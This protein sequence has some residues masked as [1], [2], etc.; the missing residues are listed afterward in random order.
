MKLSIIIPVYNVEK[1][2]IDC[3]DSIY[4]NEADLNQVE[5]LCIDDK[6]NDN[7]I[8]LIKEYVKSNKISNLTILYHQQNKGLSEARNTGI[9]QATGKYICFL[10]SD[11]MIEMS[12]LEKMVDKAI[13]QD[14]D[15]LEGNMKEVSE[16]KVNIQSGIAESNRDT[17]N[18]LT[19]DEYFYISTKSESYFPMACSRIYRSAYLKGKFSFKP[20]LKFED[21]EFS[22]RVII[23]ANRIQY[24]DTI[25][26]IY[27]RR[28]DSI[29]TN[30]TKNNQW[31]DSYLEIMNSLTEFAKTIRDKKSYGPLQD[32]IANFALSILKN[33]IAYGTTD[34]NLIEIINLVK[35]KKL[36]KIP[37][38]SKNRL[39]K[40]QGYL[41]Q[42]PKL[43]I[44]IYKKQKEMGEEG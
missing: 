32:R 11:D 18:I 16:T 39:I 37:Q 44:R 43:F 19:G 42:Y 38:K 1:Y 35:E 24:Y 22:P 41:M 10:D 31:I 30:M 13:A 4:Q 29:T 3:L 27:R 6:G 21:E 8:K 28:D 9:S 36:Y 2:I 23:S 7:S 17:T 26:Y 15:I 40:L 14:L 33:P 12:K 34:E 25:F 20:G 5:V